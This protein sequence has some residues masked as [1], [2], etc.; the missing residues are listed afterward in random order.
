VKFKTVNHAIAWYRMHNPARMK[1]VNLFE[2]Q[3]GRRSHCEAF[4][5]DHN[6]DIYASISAAIRRTLSQLA[7]SEN[8]A[9]IAVFYSCEIGNEE[10][11]RMHPVEAA[12]LYG[13]A[14]STIYR[15][16]ADIRVD[17]EGE[18]KRREL[19]TD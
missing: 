10:G 19:L 13:R 5:G 18:L 17:L 3:S 4:S 16:L 2:S 6:D 15:W 1:S 11:D 8:K 12:Q 7:T 14:V 9:P